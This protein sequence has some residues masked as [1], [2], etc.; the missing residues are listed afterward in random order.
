MR[1]SPSQIDFILIGGLMKKALQSETGISSP[2]QLVGEDAPGRS[3]FS[4]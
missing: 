1:C 3:E 2:L 4:I